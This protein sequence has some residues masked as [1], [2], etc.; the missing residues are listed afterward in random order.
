MRSV[1]LV[2]LGV[3]CVVV[4]GL[5]A[6]L[7]GG[8]GVAILSGTLPASGPWGMFLGLLYALA[9]FVAVVVVPILL[10]AAGALRLRE[11]RQRPVP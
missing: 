5:A 8:E 2:K 1:T 9:Y 6:L 3:G 10:F 4:Y 7:G 11:M